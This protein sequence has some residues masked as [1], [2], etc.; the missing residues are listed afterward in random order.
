MQKPPSNFNS[1]E[2]SK[3]VMRHEDDDYV[4]DRTYVV[5]AAD[6]ART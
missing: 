1:T 4:D 2:L 6:E 5:P 3:I